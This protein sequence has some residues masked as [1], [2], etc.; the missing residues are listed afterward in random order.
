MKTPR[1]HPIA[2]IVGAI[3]ESPECKKDE[4]V[5]ATREGTASVAFPKGG[6]VARNATDE[7]A[8]RRNAK[9]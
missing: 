7:D 1:C 3:H 4:D 6:K 9:R 8:P 2:A 5:M